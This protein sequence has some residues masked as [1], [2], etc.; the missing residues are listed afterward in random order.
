MLAEC[1]DATLWFLGLMVVLC[2]MLFIRLLTA[3]A[4]RYLFRFG[5]VRVTRRA[6]EVHM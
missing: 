3:K 5:R 1:I 2:S 4:F 6:V